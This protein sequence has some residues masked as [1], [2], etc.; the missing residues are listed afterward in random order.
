MITANQEKFNFRSVPLSHYTTFRIGGK[1]QMFCLIST[2]KQLKEVI[3][4]ARKNTFPI[5]IIGNGSNL[6]ISDQGLSGIT[7]KLTGDFD[8]IENIS[9]KH[10]DKFTEFKNNYVFL[11]IGSAT[12]LKKLIRYSI[13]HSLTS[14]EFLWG[15]PGSFGG[16]VICNT[17]AFGHSI[18][19]LI[20]ELTGIQADGQ[21]KTL[22]RRQITF[23]YRKTILPEYLIITEGI[24]KL[25]R[26]EIK[27]IKSKIAEYQQKRKAT[28][29]TGL[30][31]G[32][33][34][35]NPKSVPA[36]KLIDDC[37]LKG[38]S[39]GNAYVS[40]KHGNFIINR[41][42]AQFN[43]VYELIQIIK[44]IVEKKYNIILEEEIQILPK[45]KTLNS[46]R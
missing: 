17:G 15:I 18:G 8:F 4:F 29:P 39:V 27:S 43:D 40:E 23:R 12:P 25:T 5:N 7:I 13:N 11:K 6:L 44:S 41:G 26:G 45:I 9:E 10:T 1:A 38:L 3:D 36:G 19:D 2:L 14:A 20:V 31:A 46:W 34:F 28:Q 33:V 35:K 37:H 21:I 16:A 22:N 32:S 24:I 30:C 42:H